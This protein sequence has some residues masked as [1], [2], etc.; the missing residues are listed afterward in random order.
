MSLKISHGAFDGLCSE[1]HDWRCAVAEMAGYT[2]EE[3]DCEKVNVALDWDTITDDNIRGVW[4]PPPTD[5]LLVLFAHSDVGGEIAPADALRL[6]GRLS[7]LLTSAA[8]QHTTQ[9]FVAA[10]RMA[11]WRNEPMQFEWDPA[12]TVHQ[13][14]MDYMRDKLFTDV[15]REQVHAA[16]LTVH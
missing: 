2:T 13:L 8:W 10:C 6:A 7:E 11:V 5:P 1:F 9:K 14:V 4:T 12:A 16:G 15:V 3:D